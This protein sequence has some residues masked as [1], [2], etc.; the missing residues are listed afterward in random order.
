MASK[1]F[2]DDSAPRLE[3]GVNKTF[4][5]SI[6]ALHASR[7]VVSKT[8]P[9]LPKDPA[10]M[11]EVPSLVSKPGMPPMAAGWTVETS[12]SSGKQYFFHIGS[13]K[14]SYDVPSDLAPHKQLVVQLRQAKA[15][16]D[17]ARRQAKAAPAAAPKPAPRTTKPNDMPPPAAQPRAVA[18][19]VSGVQIMQ[20]EAAKAQTE[21]RTRQAMAKDYGEQLQPIMHSVLQGKAGQGSTFSWETVNDVRT[22][23][24]G[25]GGFLRFQWLDAAGQPST[26]PLA[27][28][29]VA[30]LRGRWELQQPPGGK[31]TAREFPV[32]THMWR[33][34]PCPPFVRYLLADVADDHELSSVRVG[35]GDEQHVVVYNPAHPP[36]EELEAAEKEAEVAAAATAVHV[37]TLARV[38]QRKAHSVPKSAAS[39]SAAAGAALAVPVGGAKR[40]SNS[41]LDALGAD[42]AKRARLMASAATREALAQRARAAAAA[43]YKDAG[44]K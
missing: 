5:E 40:G 38:A 14:A 4:V 19:S 9:D 41:V 21:Q 20:A 15:A 28:D 26:A 8:S 22:A 6:I 25:A 37:D 23:L 30:T 18:V 39:A 33:S 42:K 24:H 1:Q 32:N 31:H 13:K 16:W 44:G 2:L 34:P 29:A 27:R 17:T 35:E 10:K 43:D 11:A 12:K 3:S 7:G 36:P